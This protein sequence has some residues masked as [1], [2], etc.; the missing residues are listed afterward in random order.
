MPIEKYGT[1][2]CNLLM[3][4]DGAWP[5]FISKWWKDVVYMEEGVGIGGLMHKSSGRWGFSNS[6][7]FL[8]DL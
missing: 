3:E 5:R 1:R 6:A 8:N 7:N 2:V 4:G